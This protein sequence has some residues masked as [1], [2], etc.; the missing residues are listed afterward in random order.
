MTVRAST[1]SH[2]WVSVLAGQTCIGHVIARGK[3]GYEAFDADG[4]SLGKFDSLSAAATAI[5]RQLNE[6]ISNNGLEVGLP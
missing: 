5:A 2:G 4:S 3:T 1:P 6:L